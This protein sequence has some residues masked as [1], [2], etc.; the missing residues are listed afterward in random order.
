MM[1]VKLEHLTLLITDEI[2]MVGFDFFQR[3]NQIV[4]SIKGLTGVNWGNL[5][6]LTV[7]DLFQLPPV[8][9]MP[10]Y[11]PPQNVNSLDDLTPNGWEQF[12]LHEL[13]EVMRQR[14]MTFANALNNIRVKQPE[15]CSP[16]DMM[17]KGRELLLSLDDENYPHGA[18]HVYA[19]NVYCD[20]WNE[21]M[22]GRL[23]GM[24]VTSTVT[25]GRKDTSTNLASVAFSDKPRDTGN[26]WHVLRL[27]V[28]AHVMLTTN[29]DV[30]D[31][32]TNGNK[33]VLCP[34]FF[35]I[36]QLVK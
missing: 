36:I 13:T 31:G 29:V 15:S 5:C 18:M 12:Q 4:T 26:L 19:Q 9:S 10:I 16:E 21:Y 24:M 1:Q 20:D 2:S 32:L 14:N 35:L 11:V 23:P 33:G 34:K 27:K 22:M 28:G 3:M 30:S 7:S 25:D 17:L 8:A 6:V